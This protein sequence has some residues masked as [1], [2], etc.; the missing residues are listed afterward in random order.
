MANFILRKKFPG[1]KDEFLPTIT[2]M[3]IPMDQRAYI[4]DNFARVL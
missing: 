4:N 1:Y 3:T 2:H